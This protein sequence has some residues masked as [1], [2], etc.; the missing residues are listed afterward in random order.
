VHLREVGDGVH[1][2]TGM[3]IDLDDL[4]RTEMGDEQ[5]AAL[6]IQASVVEPRI[7]AWQRDFADRTQRQRRVR[8]LT[9]LRWLVG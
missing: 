1:H 7:T 9:L 2:P 4:V 5:Q 8:T 3:T 6:R